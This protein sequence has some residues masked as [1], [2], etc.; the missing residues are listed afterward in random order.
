[1][2]QADLALAK[3]IHT[4]SNSGHTLTDIE[5]EPLDHGGID[6]PATCRQHLRNG[7]KGAKH[8][9]VL[10]S[11]HALAP[12]LLDDLCVKQ[13]GQWRP[14]GFGMGTL[15]L[16]AF[17]LHPPAKVTHDGREVPLEAVAA[18][19]GY[20]IWRQHAFDPVHHTL[21][22]LDRP[23]SDCNGHKQLAHGIDSRPDPGTARLEVLEGLRFTELTV[24]QT[25]QHSVELIELQLSHVHV[26]QEIAAKRLKLFSR[27]HQPLQDG[28]GVDFK[29]PSRGT[30]AQPFSQTGQCVDDEV[31]RQMLAM[32]N[33]AVRCQKITAT[34][35]AVKLSPR[36]TA[37]MA[38]GAQV[39]QSQPAAVV[40]A[41]MRTEVH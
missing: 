24:S 29:H 32:E 1:M 31:H 7:F 27:L 40:A 4:P 6:L 10:H 35:A 15:V 37:G 9:P 39:I 13:A 12:V 3:G 21:S 5:I 17:G 26:T 8:D 23:W 41:F 19:G 2:L 25:P 33:R 18:P 38:V 34:G 16:K 20:T 36:P 22:H 28:I 30:D 14:A 11:H